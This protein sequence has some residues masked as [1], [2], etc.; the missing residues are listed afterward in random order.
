MTDEIPINFNM[1]KRRI[2]VDKTDQKVE[3]SVPKVEKTVQQENIITDLNR[4]DNI[5]PEPEPEQTEEVEEV[6]EE[7][8]KLDIA[9]P[10]PKPEVKQEQPQPAKIKKSH[11]LTVPLDDLKPESKKPWLGYALAGMSLIGA[12]SLFSG[13]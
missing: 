4:I 7:P 9:V 3:K 6:D 13:K 10:V 5:E 1:L 11:K 8:Q 12:V 2:K